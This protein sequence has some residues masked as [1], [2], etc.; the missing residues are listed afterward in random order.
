M[1]DMQGPGRVGGNKF[2]LHPAARTCC[3][4]AVSFLFVEYA[5]DFP[6]I[7]RGTEKKV[8]ESR[9]GN[10]HFAHLCTWR[11]RCDQ[12]FC[13]FTRLSACRL[14]QQHRYIAGEIT[15]FAIARAFDHERNGGIGRQQ[16]FAAQIVQGLF[17]EETKWFF[18]AVDPESAAYCRA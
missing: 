18:H 8:D 7:G 11:Q 10:F 2:N 4:A 14:G 16:T 1:A 5:L 12:R 6:M 17:D 15:M 9:A 13:K 3:R